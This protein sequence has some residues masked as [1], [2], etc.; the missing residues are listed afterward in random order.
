MPELQH[1]KPWQDAINSAIDVAGGKTALMR[2]L[3]DLNPSTHISSHNVIAQW[4][5]NGVPAKYCPDIEA[6]TGIRC[7]ALNFD[8]NWG[9][10]RRRQLAPATTGAVNA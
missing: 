2:K 8:T 4:V 9:V 10:L 5:E 6:I 7:E 1:P 3:N